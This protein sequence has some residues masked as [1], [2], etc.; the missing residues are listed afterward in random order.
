MNHPKSCGR[1]RQR[2]RVLVALLVLVTAYGVVACSTQPR[3]SDA[4]RAA[5]AGIAA[6]V[7]AALLADPTLYARHIEVA[8]D[9]GVVELGGFVWSSTEFRLARSDAASVRGVMRVNTDMELMR[10]GLSGAGK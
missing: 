1:M 4:E 5:D 7:E 6:N 3:R 10:G 8:V 9:R 2:N